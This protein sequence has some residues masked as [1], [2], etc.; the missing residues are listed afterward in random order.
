MVRAVLDAVAQHVD[1]AAL[2]DL[3][4]ERR[5]EFL[6]GRAGVRKIEVIDQFR[7]RR[8]QESGELSQVNG[9]FAF[10]LLGIALNP[11]SGGHVRYNQAF[12]ALFTGVGL[13]ATASS[14]VFV[15]NIL[16][17]F[18]EFF[19]FFNACGPSASSGKRAAASRTSSLPVTT[20]E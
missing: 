16:I 11:A 10:V 12:Q 1:H 4:L 19:G 9:E 3:A 15:F 14:R 13:H 17:E 20:S 2:G 6:P 7:L 5:Q 18:G 8:G